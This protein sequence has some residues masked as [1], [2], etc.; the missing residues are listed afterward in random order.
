MLTKKIASTSVDTILEN[1][2]LDDNG[3]FSFLSKEIFYKHYNQKVEEM[4]QN[5]RWDLE[6]ND[7]YYNQIIDVLENSNS[8]LFSA[9][10]R[11]FFRNNFYI[12]TIENKKII[13]YRNFSSKS[14]SHELGFLVKKD[15][16]YFKIG[17]LHSL[18][19]HSGQKELWERTKVKY[20]NIKQWA[21]NM[22]VNTCTICQQRLNTKNNKIVGKVIVSNSFLSRVQVS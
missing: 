16:I 2:K 1:E 20:G 3:N 10:K 17:E 8:E 21:T 12:Q 19:I 14:N 7:I 4:H 11:R 6:I 22:F 13:L 18:S 15:E 5:Y 9:N